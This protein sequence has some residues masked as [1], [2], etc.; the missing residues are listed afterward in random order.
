MAKQVSQW[1]AEGPGTIHAT[2]E[3]AVTAEIEQLLGK[4]GNGSGESL[5]PGI[6]RTIIANR[7]ELIR[8]LK[9]LPVVPACGPLTAEISA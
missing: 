8:R 9:N 1:E 3:E 5:T 2:Q 6:A 4:I 7:G